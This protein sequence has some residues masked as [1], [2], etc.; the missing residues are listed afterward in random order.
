VAVNSTHPDYEAAAQGWSRARDVLAGEDAIKAAKEKYLP[1]LDS[2][3]DEDYAA[4]LMRA[5]FFGAT[6]RTLEEFLD[7]I[8]RR[9]PSVSTGSSDKLKAFAG[10]CDL[11]G[12]DLVRYARCVVGEVLSVARCGSLVS[13][14]DDAAQ[15]SLSLWRAEDIINWRVE[16]VGQRV[17]LVE[18]VLRDSGRIRVL[19]LVES[20][21]VQEVWNETDGAWVLSERVALRRDGA[22]LPFIPFVFHGP[23]NSRP[24]P[25]RLPLGDIIAANLDHYRL[26]ADFKHGCISLLC[27]PLGSADSIGRRLCGL[28]RVRRG[29]RRS[30]VLRLGSLSSAAPGLGTSERRLSG[31]SGGWHCLAHGCW[32]LAWRPMMKRALACQPPASCAAW[33][34]WWRV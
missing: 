25:D 23:R 5:S 9:A 15:P 24:E 21:C 19:K 6:A 8:F 4:Y 11:W 14:D 16:R 34:M 10:D 17:V 32:P 33:A 26:D 7:I 2:Q 22:A 18:V 28:G 27:P 30:L 12:M 29:F 3:S 13:W 1:K 20:C 31:W